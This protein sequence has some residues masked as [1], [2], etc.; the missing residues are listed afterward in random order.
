MKEMLKRCGRKF[1]Y[2]PKKKSQTIK[3]NK[4]LLLALYYH[5]SYIQLR[6]GISSIFSSISLEN[7]II[8]GQFLTGNDRSIDV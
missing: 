1:F 3:F 8:G 5:R 7:H 2:S 4:K 6:Y